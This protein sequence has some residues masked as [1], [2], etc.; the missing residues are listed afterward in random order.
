MQAP[1]LQPNPNL[2]GVSPRNI[3]LLSEKLNTIGEHGIPSCFGKCI[4]HFG[5]DSIPYHPGE[6][7]CMDRCLNKLYEGFHI[8]QEHQKIFDAKLKA[9]LFDA[10]WV[11]QLPD[12]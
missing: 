6:K 8:A 3:V 4:T 5:D 9:G 12:S 11:K 2:P 7:A 1:A 10:P